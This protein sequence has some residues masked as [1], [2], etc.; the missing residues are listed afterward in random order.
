M[1]AY[2]DNAKNI[3][4]DGPSEINNKCFLMLYHR[5]IDLTIQA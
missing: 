5:Q 2:K 3:S 1:K 4:I